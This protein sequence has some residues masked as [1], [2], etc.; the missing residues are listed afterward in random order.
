MDHPYV[1]IPAVLLKFKK[2]D[3]SRCPLYMSAP[4]GFGKTASLIAYYRPKGALFLSGLSGAL[5]AMPDFHEIHQKYI[6][7]D[8]ITWIRDEASQNYIIHLVDQKDKQII[9]AGR[10]RLPEWLK[11][12][13]IKHEF[14]IV[15]EYTLSLTLREV[16]KFLEAYRV[17]LPEEI[18]QCITKDT[19]G[20]ALSLSMISYQMRNRKDYD[21]AVREAA[22]I[23]VFH[24]YNSALLPHFSLEMREMLAALSYFPCFNNELAQMVTCSSH[25]E[26]ILNEAR[27]IGDFIIRHED[28]HYEMRR[29]LSQYFQWLLSLE[30]DEK[31]EQDILSKAGNYFEIHDQ[32]N[33]ALYYYHR[34]KQPHEVSRLL[35]KNAKMHPGTGHY[36]ETKDYYFQLTDE[37]IMMS[38]IL[39]S[40]MSMLYSLLMKIRESE[41]WYKV[42]CDYED[43]APA[44]S[45]SK[46]EAKIQRLYLDISL[47]HRGTK[48]TIEILKNAALLMTSQN[49]KLPEFSV[50]SNLPSIMNGGKDFSKWSLRDKELAV[51]LRKPVELVL[52]DWGMGLVNISLAESFLEKGK[53]DIYEIMTLLNSGYLKADMSGKIEMCFV[54]TALTCRIHML[55][56]QSH[57]AHDIL[58]D[59]KKKAMREHASR[60]LPNIEAYQAWLLL[61]EGED[62]SEWLETKAPHEYQE[63]ILLDRF[64][65]MIKIRGY[66]KA[67]KLQE[68]LALSERM[69]TYFHEYGRFYMDM[70]NDLLQAIILYRLHQ[71]KWQEVLRRG[72]KACESYHFLTM[73]Q[74]EGAALMP[75]LE[76]SE[77]LGM[78]EDFKKEVFE[79]TTMMAKLYPYYLYVQTPIKDILTDMEYRILTYYVEGESTTHICDLCQFSYN[80]LKFHNRNLYRKLGVTSRL[81]AERK[82]KDM[83]L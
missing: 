7:I 61:L 22:R 24:Y 56:G 67:G 1:P 3:K 37:E 10:A 83:G 26:M 17:E 76:Q 63:F 5:D 11:I 23:D 14:V 74:F 55:H 64:R 58:N 29:M 21:D 18:V 16:K 12:S 59:F 38:P 9:M 28:G 19:K 48:K 41:H 31:R 8:D 32:V 66:I 4:I 34:A 75:L 54:S 15:D 47:P 79:A 43:K 80:T 39:M 70:E 49:F 53:E 51:L 42:L 6:I 45:A 69:H 25:V 82:A 2:A 73:I 46:K 65:Y 62:I 68:A 36:Y 44:R 50:T 33:K 72:L 20:H 60:L 30:H 52:G 71:P 27:T 78:S 13:F 35:I 40:G 77:D 57:I 81:E